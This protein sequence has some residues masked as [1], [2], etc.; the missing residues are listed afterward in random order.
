MA[1]RE[2]DEATPHA[3]L[4]LDRLRRAHLS[5]AGVAAL[6]GGGLL[7]ALPLVALALP[8]LDDDAWLGVPWPVLLLLT[9]YPLLVALAW[10]Y[11]RRADALDEAFLALVAEDEEPEP[12]PPDA[13]GSR[14]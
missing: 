8:A 7:A 2:L 3:Q 6:A 11:V 13:P 14:R 1:R 12:G 10:L 4:F 5:L 9:P